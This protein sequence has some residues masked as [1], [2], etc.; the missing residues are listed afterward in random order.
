MITWVVPLD[1]HPDTYNKAP[2]SYVGLAA[3]KNYS[4]LYL[5]SLYAGASMGED[6]F[7]ARWSAP[8]KLDMGKSCVRFRAVSDLDLDLIREVV[9]GCYARRVH[10]DGDGVPLEVTP[11]LAVRRRPGGRAA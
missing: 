9:S 8:R 3:Q 5:M 7:R 6:E 10:R 4:S 1:V 11:R 2:L